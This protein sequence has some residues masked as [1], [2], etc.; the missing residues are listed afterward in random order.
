[1]WISGQILSVQEQ[2]FR[3][4]T[5]TG[6]VYLLTLAHNAPLDG[7]VLATLRRQRTRVSVEFSGQPNLSGGVAHAV[8][9]G[10]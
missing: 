8:Q 2:R 10:A 1:M 5:D 3:L 9:E 7:A 4:Q 6:Q